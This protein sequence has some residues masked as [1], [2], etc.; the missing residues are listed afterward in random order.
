MSLDAPR[1]PGPPSRMALVVSPS[2]MP[3][4]VDAGPDDEA[5]T[6][7]ESPTG[8]GHAE[9]PAGPAAVAKCAS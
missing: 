4:L 2:G 7:G 5:V 3:R 6:R 9:G 8:L 1:A